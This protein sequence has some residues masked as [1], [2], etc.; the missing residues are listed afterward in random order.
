MQLTGKK[1]SFYEAMLMIT[2]TAWSMSFV[3]SKIATNTGMAPEVYLFLRYG[4]AALLLFPFALR[5]FKTATKQQVM[6]G[7][8][9]GVLFFAA[10]I[11]QTIG[12]T[13]TTPSNSSFITTI[14]VV[15][16]PFTTWIMMKHK[17]SKSIYAAVILCLIGIYV[18]NMKPGEV[19]AMNLG[20]VLTLIGAI[21]W[22][23]Q[24]TYTSMVGDKMPPSLLSFLT[25]GTLAA[26]GLAHCLLTGAL[27]TTTAAQL[28]GSAQ[29]IVLAAI[30]PTIVANLVQ[31]IAQPKVDANKAT[32]IYT[33]E[34]VFATIFSIILGLEELTMSVV[35]G[36]GI[37]M[38]GVLVAQLG[39]KKENV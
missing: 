25:F 3:W 22:A 8:S 36:G 29:S 30:F 13:M 31:V 10:M 4:L 9:M 1:T 15:I 24:V 17:P 27:A 21:G 39:G 33:L 37:I 11:F 2:T 19:L 32:V 18:L 6:M 7:C 28:S 38:A 12:I 5:H 23:L 26:C 34:A 16:A 14:Y 35:L 20:N